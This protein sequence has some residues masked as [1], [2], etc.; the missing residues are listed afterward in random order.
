MKA[1]TADPVKP[2]G[3][4][5]SVATPKVAGAGAH[6]ELVPH[7]M[8][9]ARM[10]GKLWIKFNGA[11]NDRICSASVIV[12]N[13]LNT[14]WTA[15]HCVKDPGGAWGAQFYFVPDED[16]GAE[17]VG[18][19]QYWKYVSTPKGWADDGNGYYDLAAIAFYPNE[20]AANLQTVVGA[21]GYIF[22]SRPDVTYTQVLGYPYIGRN[23]PDMDGRLR[24][25]DG[26]SSTSG[27]S[28]VLLP[29]DMRDGAS[30]GPWITNLTSWGAGYIIG[31]TAGTIP[32]GRTPS[33]RPTSA[34]PPS[35]STTTSRTADAVPTHRRPARL[36][37]GP[38]GRHHRLERPRNVAPLDGG[39]KPA[40]QLA[41]T[42]V[43]RSR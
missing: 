8:P 26:N 9:P 10:T 5:P 15:G 6:S 19:W 17:P 2:S 12:A 27:T 39:S 30:G 42:V 23:R 31:D 1:M 22:G 14:V 34:T 40:R 25:C 33:C 20:Q 37:D 24:Y 16:S 28:L 4:T 18:H 29:C 43:E 11:G 21:H 3:A 41:G 13:N 38:V 32:N 36:A 35:T 7:G